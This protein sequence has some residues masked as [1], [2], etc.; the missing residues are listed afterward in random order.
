M[1]IVRPRLAFVNEILNRLS[2]G[3][4]MGISPGFV[5][6]MDDSRRGDAPG[7]SGNDSGCQR[8]SERKRST[9]HNEEQ[10]YE[11]I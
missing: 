1:I 9:S 4:M 6:V 8:P 10:K 2:R 5:Q 3:A 7:L 11:A